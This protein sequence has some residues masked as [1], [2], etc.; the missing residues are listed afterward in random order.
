MKSYIHNLILEGEHQQLDFKFQITD[1]RKIARSLVAFANSQGGRLLIGVKDNGAI[2]GMRTE[3]EFHMI[4]AASKMY[5][6]PEVP[7]RSKLWNVDGKQ[8]L[9]VIVE[10]F[11]DKPCMAQDEDGKWWAYIRLKDQNI[12]ANSVLIKY[13]NRKKN[14]QGTLIRYSEK[15]TLLLTYLQNNENISISAFCKLAQINRYKAETILVNLLSARV[16]KIIPTEHQFY[17]ALRGEK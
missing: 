8:V 14:T 4:E 3:E 13:W 16:I 17:Y 1:S 10:P 11:D 5:C 12:L 7:F 6:R 15:E 9:E 2:A